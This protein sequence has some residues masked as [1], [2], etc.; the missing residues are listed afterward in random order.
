MLRGFA[1]KD[2]A[3]SPPTNEPILTTFASDLKVSE[4]HCGAGRILRR[5]PPS[6][7][8]EPTL[9][10]SFLLPAVLSNQQPLN[11]FS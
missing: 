11:S 7:G 3:W 5:I 1:L 4:V 2:A 8:A 6:Y 9:L 10:T